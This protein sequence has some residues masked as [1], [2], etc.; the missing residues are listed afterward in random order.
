MS[1]ASLRGRDKVCTLQTLYTEIYQS[2]PSRV[3]LPYNISMGWPQI[4]PSAAHLTYLLLSF[5]LIVFALF[6]DLI[7]NRA[8]LSE[9]PLATFAGI[10][11]GP[12]GA[13]VLNP[14]DEWGWADN[15]TQELARVI[16]GVQCFAV[17]I[18]LPAGY[19]KRHWKSLALLLGPN[20]IA[21]WM[22]SA[23]IIYLVLSTTWVNA[24][25]V[26][27]CLT[28]TD[29]VLSASVI[30][31]TRFSQR[32]PKRIRNLLAAESGCNDGTA[33]PFLYA[34]LYA[35][36]ASSAAEGT[37]KWFTDLL[38]WQ[39]LFGIAV[40]ITI[41]LIANK[42]LRYSEAKGF[43]QEST[44][45]VFYFLL[46][47]FCVAVGST[48]GLDDFLVCFTAGTAFC[49]D[50]WFSKRTARMKLSSIL[51]L[52]INSTFFVYFGSIIPW[53]LYHD[54]LSV[55]KMLL[56]VSLVLALRRLPV[57][58]AL[59]R[60]IPDLHT[61]HEASFTGHF[62][63]IGVGALFLAIEARAR[64]ET[65]TSLPLP[66][67]PKDSPNSV[68]LE[69]IWPAVCFMVL[70]SIIVHGFSPFIMSLVGHFSR[71]PKER[72]PLLAAEE[73]RF[74]GMA[75]EG[76]SVDLDDEDSDEEM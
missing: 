53:S 21:G 8:H 73:E 33:F 29:P 66:H 61:Y 31:E 13:T 65:G 67:P 5:F 20:M 39:C 12:R 74:Y 47:I 44:L 10:A 24:M 59:K 70:S 32:I 49:W 43:V 64:L 34:A 2:Q 19:V 15:L 26:A 75:N 28:P 7:R 54:N 30:A 17:G 11:F 23:V 16:T 6:S 69:T 48:L 68:A 63:P 25:I 14:I 46:A 9:P 18:D 58:I 41:G 60:F 55:G 35:A 76:A 1:Y 27:A 52:M 38:I 36:L 71:H 57:M 42:L 56:C 3:N 62:G 45:F 37:R 51:D 72:A 50:G 4:E 40:G 22:I